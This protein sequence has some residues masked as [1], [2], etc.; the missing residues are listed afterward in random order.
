MT[1]ADIYWRL[2]DFAHALDWLLRGIDDAE[3]IGYIW[4]LGLMIGNAGMIYARQGEDDQALCL[5]CARATNRARS[6]RWAGNCA[7]RWATWQ[8]SS[9]RKGTTIRLHRS[10]HAQSPWRA[11]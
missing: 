7:R 1:I 4:M 10:A 9:R 2:D 8:C 3:E 6:G 11:N 5:L